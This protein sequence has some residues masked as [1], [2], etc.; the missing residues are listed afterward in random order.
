MIA[1]GA[2]EWTNV[3]ST[4]SEV[5]WTRIKLNAARIKSKKD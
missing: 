3:K 5:S 2:A 4:I 1:N